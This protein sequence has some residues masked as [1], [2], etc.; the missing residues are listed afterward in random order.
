[1]NV[2]QEIN[3]INQLELKNGTANTSASWHKKYS[4]SAWVYVG[5]LPTQLSEGDVICIMSQYG[6]IEDVNLV[7]EEST[8]KSK[9]FVFIKYEDARSCILAVDNF[10]GSK[11]LGRSIRVDHVENYRLPKHVREREEEKM[12]MKKMGMG[13]GEGSGGGDSDVLE[14]GHAYE[15]KELANSYDIQSGHD[16]FAPVAA[17]TTPSSGGIA[18]DYSDDD[19][20]DLNKE[21]KKEAKRKR[22]EE[23]DRKR[24]EKERRKE[25][26][27]EKRRLKRGKKMGKEDKG[28]RK[29]HNHHDRKRRRYDD[30]D[31]DSDHSSKSTNRSY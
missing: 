23:R 13:A 21:E 5:S 2:I 27:E 7:R 20:N 28:S 15:G 9:G 10:N 11:V 31:D 14:S 12:E 25:D 17:S 8:G 30:K 26:R 1:M 19:D 4:N 29:K 24:R 16:L 3:R 6:E 22:K 18:K